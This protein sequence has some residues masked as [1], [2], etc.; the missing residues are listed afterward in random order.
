ME[1]YKLRI[2]I[3]VAAVVV[4]AT[5]TYLF[6]ISDI[7]NKTENTSM[8]SSTLPVVYMISDGGTKYNY[9]YGH[10][11][12]VN[13]AQMH[14]VV[15]PIGTSRIFKAGIKTYG[16]DINGIS[17]EVRSLSGE[18]LIEKNTISEFSEIE[19]NITVNIKLKNLLTKGQEYILKIN[20][21]TDNKSEAA[22]YTRILLADDANVDRKISYVKRFC[23]NTMSDETLNEI[24]S[25]LEPN[26]SGDNTNLG[27]V[28]IHSKLSQV[29]FGSLKPE[30]LTEIYPQIDEID[31]K[32]ASI[33]LKYQIQTSESGR[34]YE[35]NVTE[36]YRINQVS[37]DVTYVY[38]F[39]RFMDQIFYTLYGIKQ[40]GDIYLGI[41]PDDQRQ[42]RVNSTGTVTAFVEDG[43]LW[44]YHSSRDRF[45]K[46]FSFEENATD[47]FRESNRE[48][49]IKIISVDKNGNIFFLVYGYMNRGIHEGENG[50]GAYRYTPE[51]NTTEELVFIPS[52]ESYVVLAESINKLAYINDQNIL[53]FY[54]NR[55]IYYLN[56]E[57][58][59]CMLIDNNVIPDSCMMSDNY[60][61][62]YQTGDD[63]NDCNRIKIID[64]KTGKNQYI[65]C[66]S[67][68]RIKALGF[69]DNNIVYGV[70]DSNVIKSAKKYLMKALYIV[71]EN[72]KQ[73]REYKNKG[74]YITGT[75][76]YE[77]KIVIKRAAYNEEK[78]LEAIADDQLLS[79]SD[80]VS[81]N[82]ETKVSSTEERQKELYIKPILTGSVK[83]NSQQAKYVFPLD[84]SVYINNEFDEIAEYYYVFTYGRLYYISTSFEACK[85]VAS[86]TGGVVIDPNGK[87]LWDRYIDK[88]TS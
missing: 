62:M 83:V 88:K 82:A 51:K 79:N 25:K 10:V 3:Y 44:S 61:L 14:N 80:E 20:V 11:S 30:L 42:V 43:N 23:T 24:I 35:Y 12:E 29:G 69:I 22:Y 34:K 40:N 58:K 59:E 31:G 33:T 38:S 41:S 60:T 57:T 21:L 52:K 13:Y 2:F 27:H 45:N 86:N 84:A 54:Q 70:A 49:D 16:T 73:V 67:T 1:K 36:F 76:F 26:S 37:E 55:S 87:K 71:D 18:E 85:E 63:L 53:Y 77:A 39:D 17:Y 78:K 6:K 68:E 81:K 56:Y 75:D 32:I 8:G 50:I 65:E 28:N 72:C 5:L 19:G 46:V 66:G 48:H 4:T 64:L 15:T 74:I 47:G 7:I 9:L